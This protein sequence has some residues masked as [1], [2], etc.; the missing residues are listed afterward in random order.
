MAGSAAQHLE[1]LKALA[2][3]PRHVGAIAPSGPFL[4]RAMAAQVDANAAGPVLELGPGTGV[5]TEALIARGIA[6]GR[7]TAVEYDPEFAALV[8]RRFPGATVICGDA[9]DLDKTLSAHP[10]A[11]LAAAV[12]SLP[13]VNFP[14]ALRSKVLHDVFARLEP[15][16]PFVQFSYRLGPPLPP[17]DG[18]ALRKAAVI[19]LNLPPARVWV[20]SVLPRI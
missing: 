1:F 14:R 8:Q 6:P 4:A 13:L 9:F 5:V 19:W 20:Y 3:R 7:I 12:S 2:T 10:M 18:I 16:A 17:P 15:G 11:P